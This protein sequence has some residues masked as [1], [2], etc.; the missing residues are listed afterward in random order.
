M[1]VSPKSISHSF[2]KRFYFSIFYNLFFY[3]QLAFVFHLQGDF[4]IYFHFLFFSSSK[5]SYYLSQDFF[6]NLFFF[7]NIW[8]M[9][10]F[11]LGFMFICK[12]FFHFM[13][14]FPCYGT[15]FLPYLC[16]R[17]CYGTPYQPHTR[18]EL[19]IWLILI[20]FNMLG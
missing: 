5:R 14:L 11:I 3:T 4:Y 8:M 1:V 6:L 20:F 15:L 19:L 10:L 2:V 16:V 17:V 7:G 18:F 13:E 12:N 9:N